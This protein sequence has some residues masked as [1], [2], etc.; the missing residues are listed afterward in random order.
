M[1]DARDVTEQRQR[2]PAGD[3]GGRPPVTTPHDLAAVAQRLFVAHGFDETSVDDIAAAAGIGRRTFFRY[4]ATKADVLFADSPR[5]L[6]LLRA[7]LA[8]ARPGEPYRAVVTRAVVEALR[9][10]PADREWALHRAHLIFTVPAA[11][12]HAVRA[13][14]QW[15]QIAVDHA[16]ALPHADPLFPLAVGHG[17]LAGTLAAH[18]QWLTTPDDDLARLLEGML[19]LLLPP[20]PPV[21]GGGAP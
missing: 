21:P 11:Q 8:G 10:A 6:A 2:V 17:V 3:R 9:T 12:A 14:A 16:R 19:D 1:G 20:E 5:E 4:F 18:E 7:G 13:W 15:R